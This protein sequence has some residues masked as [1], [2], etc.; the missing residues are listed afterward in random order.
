MRRDLYIINVDRRRN[1]YS[2]R[3]FGHIIKNCR[4]WGLVSQERK[5]EYGDNLNISNISKRRV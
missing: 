4:N 1:C 5:I 3:G 2:C